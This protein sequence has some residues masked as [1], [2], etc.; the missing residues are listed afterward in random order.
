MGQI[1]T[2]DTYE[3]L[4]IVAGYADKHGRNP[5]LH[6]QV[7]D[8]AHKLGGK[9]VIDIG[10]GPGQDAYKFAELG[11]SVT[12]IDYSNAM[13]TAAKNFKISDNPPNFK[14]ADMRELGNMFKENSFD[15]AWISASLIHITQKD[16]PKVLQ[17]VRKIVV[18]GGKVYIG[19]KAGKQGAKVVTENKYG[20]PMEREFVFWEEDNFRRIAE[21]NGLIIEKQIDERGGKTG[22]YETFWLNYWLKVDK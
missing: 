7:E 22:D 2:K 16:V 4:Q 18:S 9:R 19:L 21:E 1:K 10:C 6:R 11:F 14:A 8:F 3:D 15:G 5:K 12:G 17:G 20:K 13:I